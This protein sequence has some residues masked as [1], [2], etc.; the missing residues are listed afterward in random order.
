MID[1][2]PVGYVIGLMTLALAA[3]MLA[4]ALLD[5]IAGDRDWRAFAISAFLT[6]LFG[7]ALTLACDRGRSSQL[8]LQQ[9]FLLTV[10]A[11][12]VL[13]FFGALPFAIGAPEARAVD[14]LFESVSGITATGS[15]VFTGL[16]EMPPGI[17]L[18]R[19]MLQWFGGLGVVVFAIVFLPAL[20]VGGMQM[21]RSE[22]F[23]ADKI[24][25]D[26]KSVGVQ[27]FSFYLGLTLLCALVY[28]AL[29]MSA[30]DALCHAMTTVA[31]GGFANYDASFAAFSPGAQYAAMVF[32]VTAS[33][34][35]VQYVALINRLDASLLLKDQ[36]VRGFFMLGAAVV[37]ALFIWRLTA[38]PSVCAPGVAD[39]SA[40]DLERSFREAMFNGLSILSG[41]GYASANYACWGAF[42][43]TLLFIIGLI[44]GC[45]G[46]TCSGIK[47]FRIQVLA[48]VVRMELRK[49]HIPRG[50]F[51]ARFNG[52]KIES[53]FVASVIVFLCIFI[54]SIAALTAALTALGLDEVT[55]LSSA[56]TAI[57]N[58]GPGFGPVVGP[59][60]H[61]GTLPDA[62]K[63]LLMV[64]MI[65]GRLEL[66][67][68]LIML[69]P[70]FWRR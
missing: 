68:V 40:P 60:G 26:A 7:G 29:G 66:I 37:A 64:G 43:V 11:W 21:F 4:P 6:G 27:I 69:S 67:A 24:L 46:S 65:L 53:P 28:G 22:A 45:A 23:D 34:P 3:T 49:S 35:F 13:P 56:A 58:I 10:L 57:A 42:P 41:T 30:F 62:A 2:R 8:S 5:W 14:A 39:D 36:Q 55:A 25:P 52:R 47:I 20:G 18:W 44:G 12:S 9:T 38:L 61:F 16:D 54:A 48:S 19:A 33:L 32:M 50:V 59:A 17:L 15:T 31:T 1:F 51:T 70:Y 63:A